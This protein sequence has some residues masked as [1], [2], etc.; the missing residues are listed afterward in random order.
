MWSQDYHNLGVKR[1]REFPRKKFD[2]NGIPYKSM[3]IHLP[4]TGSFRSTT[5]MEILERPL[6]WLRAFQENWLLDYEKNGQPDWTRYTYPH[7]RLSPSSSGISLANSRLL[8]I[9]TAGAYYP[10]VHKPFDQE[11]P[12]GDYTIRVI[13]TATPPEDLA[14]S[15][16]DFDHR[17]VREDPQVLVPLRHLREMVAAGILGSLAPVFVSFSGYQPHA[18]R[19]VK[20][21]IPAIL[22]VAKEHQVHAALIIPAGHLCI[23]SA[24]LVARALEVNHIV[25][26]LTAS[27]ADMAILTAPPRVTTTFLPAGS[28][29]GMPGNTAQQLRVL[30]TTLKLLELKAPMEITYLNESP[31]V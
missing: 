10:G 27:D 21:L 26:T 4:N 14:F 17:Y 19:V 9:S 2:Q 1:I 18:I 15:N 29:L 16:K 20:E 5:E 30:G 23:Q 13:P 24:G 28:A 3:N 8:L 11:K 22:D 31:S 25:T 6:E 7:N 12:L